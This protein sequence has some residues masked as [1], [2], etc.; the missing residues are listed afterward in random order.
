MSLILNDIQ[1]LH[2]AV[3]G[4]FIAAVTLALLWLANRKLGISA[5]FEDICSLVLPLPYFQRHRLL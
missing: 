3:A 5:G 2:W 1:P 4:A